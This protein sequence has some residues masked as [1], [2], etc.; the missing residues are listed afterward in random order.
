MDLDVG[1]LL[2]NQDAEPVA[3]VPDRWVL[4]IMG[5]AHEIR[6]HRLDQLDVPDKVAVQRGP[7]CR[8]MAHEANAKTRFG[9]LEDAVSLVNRRDQMIEVGRIRRPQ[10]RARQRLG[11]LL[12][13]SVALGADRGAALERRH[14]L[15]RSVSDAC[16]DP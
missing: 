10:V 1:D 6:A 12:D 15:T 16:F 2:P 11:G 5:G 13:L 3:R 7:A 4:R 14:R 8:V 9:A